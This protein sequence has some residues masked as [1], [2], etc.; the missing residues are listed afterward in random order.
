MSSNKLLSN[1]NHMLQAFQPIRH[2]NQAFS[3]QYYEV[4]GEEYKISENSGLYR[5]G[6]ISK[7][8]YF[9]IAESFKDVKDK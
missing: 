7:E 9:R 6:K 8:E 4:W 5:E 3:K 2:K 1:Q